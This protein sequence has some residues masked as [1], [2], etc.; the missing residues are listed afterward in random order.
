MG[1]NNSNGIIKA[2][3][4]NR[5]ANVNKKNLNVNANR[6]ANANVNKKNAN[7]NANKKNTNTTRKSISRNITLNKKDLYNPIGI[8][9]PK[10]EN[11]NPLTGEPYSDN[12]KSRAEGWIKLPM[13]EKSK[14]AIKIPKNKN[15][16]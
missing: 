3:N 13:Y 14:D 15:K 7:V 6:N 5:N 11:P 10:G 16:E 2:N 8:L 1:G 4:A 9:D 12:Y